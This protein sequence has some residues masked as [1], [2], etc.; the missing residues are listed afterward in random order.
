MEKNVE[1]QRADSLLH[2]PMCY[3]L[4]QFLIIT[5]ES[6]Y[7]KDLKAYFSLHVLIVWL[8]DKQVNQIKPTKGSVY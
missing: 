3:F 8:T 5:K 6:K 1:D 2:D 7:G 4:T